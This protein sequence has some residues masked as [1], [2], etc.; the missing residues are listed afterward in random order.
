MNLVIY[1]AQGIALGAYL[2]IHSLYP[3]RKIEC[4]LVTERKDNPE[5]LAGLPV[6]ELDSYADKLPED[7]KNH[8]EILIATPENLMLEIEKKLDE[9]GL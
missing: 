1:G 8:M 4:F 6:F 5:F 3:I 9:K 2:S 7:K